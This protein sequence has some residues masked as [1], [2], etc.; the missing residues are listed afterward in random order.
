[1]LRAIIA[2]TFTIFASVFALNE[3]ASAQTVGTGLPTL[4]ELPPEPRLR[5]NQPSFPMAC[6]GGGNMR[7]AMRTSERPWFSITFDKA[8]TGVSG[9]ALLPGQCAWLDRPLNSAEPTLAV[10]NDEQKRDPIDGLFITQ[11]GITVAGWKA[12]DGDAF[13]YVA[14]AVRSGAIFYFHAYTRP[15]TDDGRQWLVITRLG[16]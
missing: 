15:P 12:G 3:D 16:P 4:T 13:R 11:S 2:F 8:S 14:D 10:F 6:M 5:E 7:V 9:G 1:M